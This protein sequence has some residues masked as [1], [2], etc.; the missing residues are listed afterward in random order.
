MQIFVW[1]APILAVCALLFALVKANYVSKQSAGNDKMKE[2]AAAIAEGA[3]AF[4]FAEYKILAVFIVVLLVLIG[5]FIGID[6]AACTEKHRA[7]G[8]VG[9]VFPMHLSTNNLKK[10]KTNEES[11]HRQESGYDPDLR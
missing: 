4:L 9:W 5:A 11:N 10:E 8:H 2:I 7:T 1:A 6:T 3:N